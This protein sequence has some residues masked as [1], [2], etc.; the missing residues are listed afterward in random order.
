[1][2]DNQPIV[3]SYCDYIENLQDGEVKE[4]NKKYHDTQYG[5]PIHNDNELFGR[6]IL[7]INQA[8]LSWITMLK[9]QDNFRKAFDNFDI[10]KIATYSEKDVERLL[11][12]SGIIRNK[13]KINA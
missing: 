10:Q 3:F 12:D 9:K 13:L 1:M 4:L 11:Q 8:G 6:L 7:E 2:S 5:F